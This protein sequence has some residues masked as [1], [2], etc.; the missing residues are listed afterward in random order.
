MGFLRFLLATLVVVSHVGIE[1][2]GYNVGVWAV[3]IFY[4]LAGHVVTKLWAKRPHADL[5]PSI[6]WFYTDR[7]LRIYPLYFAALLVA[8]GIWL[9]GAKSYYLSEASNIASWLGN[10]TIVPLN[11]YMYN[12]IDRFTL[13]P[14]AWSLGAE[15]QFYLIMPLLLTYPRVGAL[16]AAGSFVVFICAHI[17][18]LHA[19]WYGYRLLFGVLFVF[20]IGVLIERRTLASRCLLAAICV[21]ALLHVAALL[22]TGTRQVPDLEVSAGILLGI[23]L[24]LLTSKARLSPAMHTLQQYAGATSYGLFVFHFPM[25]WLTEPLH[26]EK[27]W[28]FLLVFGLALALAVAFHFILERPLWRH[29]R[30]SVAGKAFK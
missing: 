8:T 18:V 11:Y 12:G 26:L 17:G 20:M 27:G 30:T 5:L 22:I 28:Q 9:S 10:L 25:I 15:L 3:I 21:L 16:C 4:M 24:I 7:L 19:D 13:I 1:P 29:L 14:P 23:P 2:L 6:K